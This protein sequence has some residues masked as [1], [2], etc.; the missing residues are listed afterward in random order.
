MN[1]IFRNVHAVCPTT[2]L[3]GI[4]DVAV[5]EGRV[6]AI[7]SNLPSGDEEQDCTGLHLLPGLVDLDCQLGDPGLEDR[8]TLSSG[9]AAAAAGGFTTVV[10]N[11]KTRP[12]ID[13]AALVRELLG[14]APKHTNVEVLVAGALTLGLKGKDLAEMGLMAKAGAVA[15]SNADVQVPDT[16]TLRFALLYGRPFGRPLMV[17]AGDASLEER[18]SMHEGDISTAIGLRGLPAAA[19]EIGVAR[20][21]A[22]SRGTGAPVHIAGVSTEKAV[23]QIRI[24]KSEGVPV[25]ASTSAHHLLLTDAAVRDSVYSTSTRLLPPLRSEADREALCAAVMDRTLDAVVSQHDPW[26]RVDKELE[27]E[28][29][30]PGATGLQTAFNETLEALNNDYSAAVYAL[31][32]GPSTLLGRETGLSAGQSANF[33]LWDSRVEWALSEGPRHSMCANTPVLDRRFKGRVVSTFR[34]GS[35]IA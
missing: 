8:E 12:V 32:T 5:N 15:F 7:G 9:G 13:D 2:G 19:E 23:D 29:A 18:G 20:L 24:A 25:T 14:R 22:L 6:S 35:K 33:F 30:E 34:N 10:V 16:S 21:V 27:F 11:P 28:L 4:V 31:S 1:R 26:T 17:R 3:D